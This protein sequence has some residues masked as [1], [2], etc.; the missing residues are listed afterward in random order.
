MLE[1]DWS[2]SRD[3]KWIEIYHYARFLLKESHNL[4]SR[5]TQERTRILSELLYHKGEVVWLENPFFYD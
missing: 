3:A 4:D 5:L 2:D 1:R